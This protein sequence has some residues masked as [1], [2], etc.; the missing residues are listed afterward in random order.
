M[1]LREEAL[2]SIHLMV[3]GRWDVIPANLLSYLE[4]EL[5]GD[6]SSDPVGVAFLLIKIGVSPEKAI[7]LLNWRD[8]EGLCER[9]LQ[10]SGF[11]TKRGLR[12]TLDGRRYEIDVVASDHEV[13]LALDCKMWSKGNSPKVYKIFE[14]AE[15]Q[16]LRTIALKHAIERRS[17]AD[18][19]PEPGHGVMVPCIVTWLDF[20]VKLSKSGVPIVPISKF[21]SFVND[22]RSLLD[23]VAALETDFRVKIGREAS[24]RNRLP[25]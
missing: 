17:L 12:F 23:E 6:P 22:I 11:S 13:T 15:H 8:F 25:L 5:G 1:E 2:R 9:G 20:G 10:I 16:Y 24:S 21:P 7:A 19:R 18:V 14:A 3:S 4:E